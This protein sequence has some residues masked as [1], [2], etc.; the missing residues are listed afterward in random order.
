MRAG[1][2]ESVHVITDPAKLSFLTARLAVT[3]GAV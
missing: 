3:V 1:R 2:I